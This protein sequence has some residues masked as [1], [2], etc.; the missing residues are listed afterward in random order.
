MSSSGSTGCLGDFKR[1]TSPGPQILH[2]AES[3][4]ATPCL[5]AVGNGLAQIFAAD[6]SCR[7]GVAPDVR[8]LCKQLWTDAEVV[9]L[10]VQQQKGGVDCG[11]FAIAF[12]EVSARGGSVEQARFDQ[13][14]WLTASEPTHPFLHH[15]QPRFPH[16]LN[17]NL[18]KSSFTNLG[19][20]ERSV[21]RL[22]FATFTNVERS[23]TAYAGSDHMF[24]ARFA[25][26]IAC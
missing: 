21:C 17:I 9:P 5:I 24:F 6:S 25:Q 8:R 19:L 16:N 26:K 22:L 2:V 14:I 13:N 20:G 7:R 15:S 4:W 11:L 12:A 23:E 1:Q 3:H 18:S 10:S